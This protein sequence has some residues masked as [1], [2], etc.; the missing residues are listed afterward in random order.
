MKTILLVDDNEDAREL[1]GLAL[2]DQGFHVC[3]AENGEDALGKL[4]AMSPLPC[5]VVLDMMMPVMSGHELLQIMGQRDR[6]ASLPVVVLSA[7]GSP[8][9]APDVKVFIR[10]PTDL[11]VLRTVVDELCGGP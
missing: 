5:L 1:V 8:R 3:E 9:E 7:G 10:K 6:Y 4:E 11:T 2:R